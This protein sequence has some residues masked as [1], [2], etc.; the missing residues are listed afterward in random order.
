MTEAAIDYTGI[1]EVGGRRYTN[2]HSLPPEICRAILKD[3]Y[4][5][6]DEES[7][8][9]S[10]STLTAPTQM[11]VLKRRHPDKLKTFDVIDKY[12][13]FRGSVSHQILEDSWHPTMNSVVE[14]RIYAD[15]LGRVV[16]GK[17]DCFEEP[18]IRDYKN[19][20][21][22]KILLGKKEGYEDWEAGQNTYAY[23]LRL[24][25]KTVERLNV[26]AFI[27]D[28]KKSELAKDPQNYPPASIIKVPLRLWSFAE[29]EMY[30]KAR[31]QAILNCEHLSD[32]EL[33]PCSKK[34]MWQRL[35]DVAIY[36]RGS[37]DRAYRKADTMAE[38]TAI[39][40][41]KGLSHTEYEI[42]ERWSGR[43]RCA[44]HCDVSEVCAQNRRLSAAEGK[45]LAADL[46]P[47]LF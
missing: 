41:E 1:F 27:G 19:C 28:W 4:T 34:E 35:M 33:P 40:N 23:L 13:Q 45:P 18:E 32:E 47:C 21:V 44:E 15:V 12:W 39:F 16:S 43:T 29:Q 9:E 31:V 14:E 2:K 24:K 38:A 46:E 6:T 26:W 37:R 25:G 36:K 42:V 3:R 10:A 22:Y 7:F 30:V 8:D 17:L 5:N 11:T 20:M